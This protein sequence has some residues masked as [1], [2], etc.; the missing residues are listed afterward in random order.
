MGVAV[1]PTVVEWSEQIR[2]YET[3][4]EAPIN[5][6]NEILIRLCSLRASMKDGASSS[7]AA[8]FTSLLSVDA[9]LASCFKTCPS[10][11]T[12]TTVNAKSSS[13]NNAYADH[14]HIYPNHAA[15]TILNNYRCTRVIIHDR[16]LKYLSD[17][18]TP[19]S[20]D[21]AR[22]HSIQRETSKTIISKITD[23][24][25][26]SVPYYFGAHNQHQTPTYTPKAIC[27]YFLRWPLF[28]VAGTDSVPDSMREWAIAQL[29]RI[30]YTM[31]I[32]QTM[33]M[34]D[35]LKSELKS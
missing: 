5:Q 31:G 19:P 17:I 35:E 18:P 9:E 22:L 24:I 4:D 10:N 13:S 16:V 28:V 3:A 8:F 7:H 6:V 15:A 32:Q 34:A 2:T 21:L 33:A 23:Q 26:A 14:Y 20:P 12:Y 30:G 1:H 29:Q 27:G 25:C 11:L